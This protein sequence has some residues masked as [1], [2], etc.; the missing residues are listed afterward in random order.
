MQTFAGPIKTAEP[1]E[2]PFW[3]LT[4]VGPVNHVLH[5]GSD[6]SKGKGKFWGL[7]C[8]FKSMDSLRSKINHSVRWIDSRVAGVTSDFARREKSATGLRQKLIN[9]IIIIIIIIMREA[10]TYDVPRW[11]ILS[12]DVVH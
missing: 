7:S 6:I 12:P 5:G 1:I 3:E 11:W 4:Q 10:L 9:H 8:P 2:M